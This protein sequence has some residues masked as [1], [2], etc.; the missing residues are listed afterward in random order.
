[1]GG[2]CVS[3]Q[4]RCEPVIGY[5]GVL[6]VGFWSSYILDGE[7]LNEAE[8]MES[9]SDDVFTS[10]TLHAFEGS[11]GSG[12]TIPAAA[13]VETRA[14]AARF[15]A[16]GD[17]PAYLGII[18]ESWVNLEGTMP[19]NPWVELDIMSDS[20]P[21]GDYEI[22]FGGGAQFVLTVLNEAGS[23]SCV[24]AV[25]MGGYIAVLFGAIDVTPGSEVIFLGSAGIPIYHPTDTPLGDIS[26]ELAAEG[27]QVCPIE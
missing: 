9:H 4:C 13:A 20:I 1:M 26:T 23:D 22:G 24:L 25:G 12:N 3:G 11:Y 15:P 6:D 18:Q 10:G 8:Y 2:E 16:I 14:M 7:R 21:V 17:K 27:R 5:Y 19:A